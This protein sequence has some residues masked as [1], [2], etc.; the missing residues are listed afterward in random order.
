MLVKE[1]VAMVREGCRRSAF[2]MGE[3]AGFWLAEAA[4]LGERQLLM[5]RVAGW[6][7]HHE[8]PPKEEI[9]RWI[10]PASWDGEAP[11]FSSWL[12]QHADALRWSATERK[13]VVAAR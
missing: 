4:P 7:R 5:D 1:W 2:V 9:H 10:S 8:P 6:L 12:R 3:P 13:W 11:E